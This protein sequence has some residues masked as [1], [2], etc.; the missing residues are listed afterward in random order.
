LNGRAADFTP[1]V[2]T[3]FSDEALPETIEDLAEDI[4]VDLAMIRGLNYLPPLACW[5]LYPARP[6]FE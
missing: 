2:T 4:S 1:F 3:F 6:S 5:Y